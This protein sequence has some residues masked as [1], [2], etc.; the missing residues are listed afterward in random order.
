MGQGQDAACQARAPAGGKILRH[1]GEGFG[2][3]RRS[4]NRNVIDQAASSTHKYRELGSTAVSTIFAQTRIFDYK[5]T[6]KGQP[7]NGIGNG[8][9][10]NQMGFILVEDILHCH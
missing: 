5:I 6:G 9:D 4:L 2:R 8:F 7:S 1:E 3:S 10:G